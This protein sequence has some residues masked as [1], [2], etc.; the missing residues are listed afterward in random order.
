[1]Q[2][3]PADEVEIERVD[4]VHGEVNH[5]GKEGEETNPEVNQQ[6]SSRQSI[7]DPLP[8]EH[9]EHEHRDGHHEGDVLGVQGKAEDY[10][11]KGCNLDVPLLNHA[12][13]EQEQGE[14]D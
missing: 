14:Q 2:L 9:Q 1:M 6:L 3:E 5:Y 12:F 7:G 8:V 10:P 13:P 4:V 11:A